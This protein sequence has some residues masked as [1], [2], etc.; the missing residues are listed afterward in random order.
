MAQKKR[1]KSVASFECA[2]VREMIP[3]YVFSEGRDVL[4]PHESHRVEQH[5]EW[6][7]PC[8]KKCREQRSRSKKKENKWIEE[9]LLPQIN[10]QLMKHRSKGN[11]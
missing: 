4:S 2:V 8:E 6:C 10:E 3:A 7:R 11:A 1:C 9:R 5:L